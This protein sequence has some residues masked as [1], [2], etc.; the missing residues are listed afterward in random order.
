M[1]LEF[2]EDIGRHKLRVY[3]ANYQY[4]EDLDSNAWMVRYDYVRV[5]EDEHPPS[6]VHVLG[7][8][9]YASCLPS[10]QPLER[11]HFPTGRIPIEA[12]IRLLADQFEVPCNCDANF[13]RPLLSESEDAFNAIAHR[14]VSGPRG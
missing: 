5:P 10:K 12:V 4:Q 8:L 3:E 13:W 7:Q 9:R 11:V 1:Q 14:P 6:H 2:A